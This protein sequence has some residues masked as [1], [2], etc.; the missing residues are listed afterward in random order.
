MDRDPPKPLPPLAPDTWRSVQGACPVCK[1]SGV[2]REEPRTEGIWC[3]SCNR[4]LT[5]K[6]FGNGK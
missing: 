2:L 6:D 3:M 5:Q 4:R 1:R